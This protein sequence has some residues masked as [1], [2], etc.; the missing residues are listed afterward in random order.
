MV[1]WGRTSLYFWPARSR[2]SA[3]TTAACLPGSSPSLAMA[4]LPVGEPRATSKSASPQRWRFA[5]AP[6]AA[7]ESRSSDLI[8]WKQ[9][10]SAQINLKQNVA[11]RIETSNA[12]GGLEAFLTPMACGL[13]TWADKGY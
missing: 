10:V 11:T 13:A 3:A 1:A 7:A 9:N 5:V 6:S 4:P 12:A 2:P 8:Y